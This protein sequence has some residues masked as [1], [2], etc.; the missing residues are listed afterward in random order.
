M[1]T[2]FFV[3]YGLIALINI[4]SIQYER[5]II[6]IVSKMCLMPI[7]IL[8]YVFKSDDFSF[9]I[10]SAM[11]FSWFGDIL[12]IRPG[13]L[14]LYAGILN[15]IAAHILY[16]LGFIDLVPEINITALVVSFL[17]VLSIE[18][19]LMKKLHIQNNYKFSVII[20]GIVIGLLVV[21]S[22]Q[23]FI[24]YKNIFGVLIFIGS[25]LFFISDAVLAYF[26]TIKAMTK[27]SLMVIML[28]YIIAQVC[29]II[30]YMNI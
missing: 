7:L 18:Y 22:I 21:F 6:R 24:W 20:Y 3:L 15:F 23:I 29:I 10:I 16:V 4:S 28:T 8:F 26:N 1:Y 25:I 13:K 2:I 12:L 11:F 27:N 14:R 17:F 30:S 5:Q 9:I 19:F